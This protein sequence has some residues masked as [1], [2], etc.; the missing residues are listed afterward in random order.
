MPRKGERR[1]VHLL[2]GEG[3]NTSV[4][5]G[6][7]LETRADWTR[8]VKLVTCRMCHAELHRRE[9]DG[10]LRKIAGTDSSEI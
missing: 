7:E 3:V 2:E 4:P 10:K 8:D 5:C 6:R 9:V 1:T